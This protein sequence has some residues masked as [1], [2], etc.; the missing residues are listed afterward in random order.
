MGDY[1]TSIGEVLGVQ[2]KCAVLLERVPPEL[3]TRLL[4]TSGSRPDTAIMRQTLESYSVARRSWQPSHPTSM[5]EA[6]MEIGA[7]NGEKGKKSRHDK[8]KKG[9]NKGK[10]KQ[11]GKHENSPKFEGDCGHCGKW[12]HKQKDCRYKNTVAEVDEV[13]S[14]EPPNSNASS[15]TN[16]VTPPPPGLSSTGSAQSTVGTISTPI[17][18]HARLDGSLLEHHVF[19]SDLGHDTGHAGI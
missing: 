3:R 14:V 8:D 5:G 12:G 17:E 11:K 1:E 4:L 18:D 2:V 16:R 19:G 13:E 10:G 6:P 7:V 15:S 9:K